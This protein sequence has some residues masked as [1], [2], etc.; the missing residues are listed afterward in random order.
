MPKPS[1]KPKEGGQKYHDGIPALVRSL[2]GR[3]ER[4]LSDDEVAEKL[5]VAVR[6]VHRWKKD[7]PEFLK[8]LIETKAVLDAKVEMS[9]FRRAV[10]Y[11]STKVEV[12]VEDGAETKRVI[13]TEEVLP[14]VGACKLWLTNRDPEHWAE[15]QSIEHSGEIRIEDARATLLSRIRALA[16]GNAGDPPEA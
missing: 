4:G 7:H 1:P 6:T 11:E 13:K 14:D 15:K 5:G 10:G 16:P 8:A 2:V 9:L 3:A 12:T